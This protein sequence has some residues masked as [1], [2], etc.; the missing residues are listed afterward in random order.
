MAE[1]SR[2]ANTT[3]ILVYLPERTHVYWPLIREDEELLSQ[4]NR[5]MIYAWEKRLGCLILERGRV[6]DD[7]KLF[8][9]RMDASLNAQ[10]DLLQAFAAIHEIAF[11]DLT[12][13]L[14]H[15]AEQGQILADPLET[16]Y[17]DS[18]NQFLAEQVADF[19]ASL[20]P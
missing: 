8:R 9:E 2:E 17:N 7:V 12:P 6:P 5:D 3:F 14:Q 18:V 20:D 15:L 1:L 10:R 13:A 11:L 4:L 16:H 19:I